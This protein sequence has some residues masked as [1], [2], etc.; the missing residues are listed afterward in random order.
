MRDL[1]KAN[2]VVLWFLTGSFSQVLGNIAGQNG[3]F[4]LRRVASPISVGR[5]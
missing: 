2:E 3:K 5:Q 1:L 4:N